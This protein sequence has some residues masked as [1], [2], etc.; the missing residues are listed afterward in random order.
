MSKHFAI[1]SLKRNI[2]I[3]FIFYAQG[4]FRFDKLGAFD[5]VAMKIYF[6]MMKKDKNSK[7]RDLVALKEMQ[8]GFD[9]TKREYLESLISYLRLSLE[10]NKR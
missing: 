2:P 10:E 1:V 4:G 6:H 9:G 8:R 5:K 7:D 3:S